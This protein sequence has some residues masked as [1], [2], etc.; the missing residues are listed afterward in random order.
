MKQL[1]GTR[2]IAAVALLVALAVIYAATP[3]L[4]PF[5]AVAAFVAVF[6]IVLASV[7]FFVPKAVENEE[8][9]SLR[10]RA[11][12]QVASLIGIATLVFLGV[13]LVLR[14]FALIPNAVDRGV[15]L[16]GITFAVLMLASPAVN[17]LLTWRPW[18]D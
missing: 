1:L 2:L 10:V 13:I 5:V 7:R 16:V 17:A 12:D 18:A 6:G 14:A 3:V 9:I 15:F 8:I 11:Q 4:F